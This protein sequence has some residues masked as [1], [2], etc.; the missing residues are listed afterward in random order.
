MG[1][2]SQMVHGNIYSVKIEVIVECHVCYEFEQSAKG[3][4]VISRTSGG[5]LES[6][7]L[8]ILVLHKFKHLLYFKISVQTLEFLGALGLHGYITNNHGKHFKKEPLYCP[9]STFVGV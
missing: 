1:I 5:T 8:T 6:Y 9:M 7:R 2:V 4:G 3:S